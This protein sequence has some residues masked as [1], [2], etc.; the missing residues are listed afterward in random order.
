[1][2]FALIFIIA[3]LFLPERRYPSWLA[4]AAL[5]VAMTVPSALRWPAWGWYRLSAVLGS[6]MSRVI[7]GI[8]FFLVVFPMGLVVGRLRGDV[9]GRKAFKKNQGSVFI[10]RRHR[11]LAQDLKNPY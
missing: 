1:M 7:L 10:D 6:V 11:Y 4:L 3:Q 2:A 9:F 5:L 8:V